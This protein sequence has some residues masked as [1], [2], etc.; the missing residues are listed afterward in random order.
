MGFHRLAATKSKSVHAATRRAMRRL[1]MGPLSGGETDL[2]EHHQRLGIIHPW[3]NSH[4]WLEAIPHNSRRKY[5]PH[6]HSNSG[7]F[8]FDLFL[9]SVFF[10]Y[11]KAWPLSNPKKRTKKSEA[12]KI[13]QHDFGVPVISE[14]FPGWIFSEVVGFLRILKFC[15]F[16]AHN[17]RETKGISVWLLIKKRC[18]MIRAPRKS[19]GEA[20]EI[21]WSY[22]L[23]HTCIHLY[24][25]RFSWRQMTSP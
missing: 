22:T 5:I 25:V 11:K 10:L 4:D 7:S 17:F 8:S 19:S 1:K 15:N 2:L 3:K 23:Q 24:L 9:F 6:L 18:G 12:E 14:H 13:D 21:G 20:L 16:R